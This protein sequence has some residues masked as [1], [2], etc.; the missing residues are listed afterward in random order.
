LFKRLTE[1][2]T[3][4]L[5]RTDV[6]WVRGETADPMGPVFLK[7]GVYHRAVREHK[8]DFARRLFNEGIV[9]ELTDIGFLNRQRIGKIQVEG[10][11]F[12]IESDAA[13]FPIVTNFYP[14]ELVRRAALKWLDA[15]LLLEKH[16]L[17]L[18]D[19]HFAN[20]GIF[21]NASPRSFDLGS[22]VET[23]PP[24]NFRY[25]VNEFLRFFFY[26]LVSVY[27]H[28]ELASIIRSR[29]L[30]QD[31]GVN[32]QEGEY[33]TNFKLTPYGTDRDRVLRALREALAG[34]EFSW[35]RTTW[36]HYNEERIDRVSRKSM[37]S[38]T[39]DSRAGSILSLLRRVL[40]PN[41]VV[42]D[43]AGNDGFFGLHAAAAGYRTIIHD[44]DETALYRG[45]ERVDREP[46]R[47][48]AFVS[49]DAMSNMQTADV[50]L[51][52]AIT[53]HLYITDHR[54]FNAIAERFS[55]YTK[56]TLITEFMPWG[57]SMEGPPKNLS[58]DYTLENFVKHLKVHFSD[59]QV[60]SQNVAE[61]GHPR[62][63][64]LCKK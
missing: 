23:P 56:S 49:G 34:L 18:I 14:F 36:S 16:G 50:V 9:D 30:S 21:G 62:V 44:G 35:N 48:V 58:K 33:L 5:R 4:V 20:F 55:S 46:S 2:R 40:K 47:K 12:T 27:R 59:V 8:A 54:Y 53:H 17:C 57:L 22:V 42:L 13:D 6:K 29:A 19:G 28:P 41:D 51:A 52:L 63:L 37:E 15:E 25:G 1:A 11:A 10:A 45:L 61:A 60:V 26:P 31:Q 3:D 39:A 38:A 43:L 64:L 24:P 32:V 7:D